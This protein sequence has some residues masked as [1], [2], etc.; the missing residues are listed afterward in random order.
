MDAMDVRL[1]SF[2]TIE[3]E[4]RSYEHDI[5]IER[6]EIRK[7][8]KATSNVHRGTF[9]HTPLSIDEDIP[10]GSEQLIVGTGAYGSLPLMPEVAA[11][12]ERR[13]VELVELPTEEACLVIANIDP[14][15]VFAVLHVTC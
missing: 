3:A 4:G 6:G 9:G 2:G 12:A 5:V 13:G 8:S 7:R 14:S 15:E 1:V 11:E 10:W